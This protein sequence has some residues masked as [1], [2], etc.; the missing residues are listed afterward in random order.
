MGYISNYLKPTSNSAALPAALVL[1]L[2]GG[3]D[4]YDCTDTATCPATSSAGSDA[5]YS[6]G[7]PSHASSVPDELATHTT[8]PAFTADEPSTEVDGSS[9][10]PRQQSTSIVTEFDSSAPASA[11]HGNPC[12]AP[13]QCQ[14]GACAE[15]WVDG[16]FICCTSECPA[17]ERCGTSGT[18]EQC[19]PGMSEDCWETESGEPIP[20]DVSLLRGECRA[21]QR[22][23]DGDGRWGSCTGAVGPQNADD[24]SVAG[25]D[26]DCDGQPNEG[27]QCEAGTSRECGTDIGACALGAQ[28]CEAG[29]WGGC[30]G[31]IAPLD[32][33]SCAVPG[34][35]SNCDGV[36]NGGCQC[37]GSASQGCGDCG[38]QLCDPETGTWGEC[39]RPSGTPQSRCA[40][41]SSTRLETCGPNGEWESSSC[42]FVCEDGGCGGTCLPGTTR[43]LTNPARRQT[44]VGGEW[45]LTETCS[46]GSECV[47]EG[48]ECKRS[49]GTSCSADNQCASGFCVGG[50]CCGSR[51][52][53]I[54]CSSLETECLS[55]PATISS[56]LCSQAGA[57]RGREEVCAEAATPEPTTRACNFPGL[58]GGKCDGQGECGPPLVSCGSDACE[59]GSEVCCTPGVDDECTTAQQCGGFRAACDQDADCASGDTCCYVVNQFSQGVFCSDDCESDGSIICQTPVYERACPSGTYC[60]SFGNDWGRCRSVD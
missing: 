60:D 40:E 58:P 28:T 48:A 15:S 29:Q 43:C 17:D 33:D 16:E 45:E 34:D 3:C 5:S 57:C 11:P 18:C 20:G 52:P 46:G 39:A 10:E 54:N 21:G 23:C 42:E 50:T 56:N 49:S 8:R 38:V 2:S 22:A 14:S 19:E 26:N 4:N 7:T 35:D 44:C 53:T 25:A 32:K 9:T 59:L 51:C 37:V 13:A 55:Y 12:T 41:G 1:S 24:C 27:C 30:E 47:N 36:A 31:G 6:S